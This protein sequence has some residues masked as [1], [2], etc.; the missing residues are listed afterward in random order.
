MFMKKVFCGAERICTFRGLN[1]MS[2]VDQ[3]GWILVFKSDRFRQM[4]YVDCMTCFS[5]MDWDGG[6]EYFLKTRL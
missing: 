5:L 1:C 3:S 4:I 2:L 6:V